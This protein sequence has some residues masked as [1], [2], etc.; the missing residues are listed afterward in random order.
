MA[1]EVIWEQ[2]GAGVCRRYWGRLSGAELTRSVIEVEHDARFD[3][4][5]YILNDFL[6]A[7]GID[8]SLAEIEELSAI[9]GAA[10]QSNPRIKVA[11]V[12]THPEILAL[13]EQYRAVG[14]NS[15]PVQLFAD[16]AAA[17]AWFSQPMELH[18]AG[19]RLR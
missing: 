6:A 12:A 1:Y 15:Y 10:E 19:M 16:V 11:V 18:F 14:L 17:R 2:G 13:A 4:L 5:R 9:D 3:N 7:E 8:Y